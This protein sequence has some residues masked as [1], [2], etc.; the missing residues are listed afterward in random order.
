MQFITQA[1]EETR[2]IALLCVNK[3][4]YEQKVYT[5]PC[6]LCCCAQYVGHDVYVAGLY[7]SNNK[8]V[9][10]VLIQ[11]ISWDLLFS[12]CQILHKYV[13]RFIQIL[14]IE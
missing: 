3:S 5:S 4:V 8:S 1:K 10:L 6:V 12:L 14:K 7:S 9:G 2:Q 13:Q 11:R